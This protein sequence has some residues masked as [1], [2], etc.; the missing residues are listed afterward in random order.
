MSLSKRNVGVVV[1]VEL[2]TECLI[3]TKVGIHQ[4]YTLTNRFLEY[5]YKIF[6]LQSFSSEII[7]ICHRQSTELPINLNHQSI[8][9]N[10]K[11]FV[12]F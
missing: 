8:I 11:S 7:V 9:N 1:T 6:K 12:L 4:L 10:L 3:K 5:E 2:V